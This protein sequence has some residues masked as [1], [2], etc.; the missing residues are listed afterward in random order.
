MYSADLTKL[1]RE[2]RGC[3][4]E[5]DFEDM[6][7]VDMIRDF[8]ELSTS[9]RFFLPP[10]CHAS[11]FNLRNM[12]GDVKEIQIP[13][14]GEEC[15]KLASQKCFMVH[16]GVLYHND[17]RRIVNTC[18]NLDLEICYTKRCNPE[19]F[20]VISLNNWLKEYKLTYEDL[21]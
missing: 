5:T 10:D 12:D 6:N 2:Y 14:L 1:L 13:R 4:R 9:Y 20:Y 19:D 3:V 7:E 17:F 16:Q 21:H 15:L 18:E 11:R 8:V